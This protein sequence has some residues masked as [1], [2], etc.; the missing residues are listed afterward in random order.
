MNQDSYSN[1]CRIKR[2]SE[3]LGNKKILTT[4]IV[5]S[6]YECYDVR[7]LVTITI[8]SGQSVVWAL[9]VIREIRVFQCIY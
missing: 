9:F 8:H 5:S 3:I 2:G 1:G 7:N 6:D 4:K